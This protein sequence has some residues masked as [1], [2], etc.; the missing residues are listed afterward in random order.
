MQQTLVKILNLQKAL[1]ILHAIHQICFAKPPPKSKCHTSI[2]LHQAAT[3]GLDGKGDT[4]CSSFDDR[5]NPAGQL[6][7]GEGEEESRLDLAF[8]NQVQTSL[9][10]IVLFHPQLSSLPFNGV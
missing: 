1:T 2:S 7:G 3:G 10:E 5:D 8:H 9:T 6:L 4:N